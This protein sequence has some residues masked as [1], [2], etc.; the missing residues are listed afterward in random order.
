MTNA[1]VARLPLRAVP[2]HEARCDRSHWASAGAAPTLV[3]TVITDPRG[4]ITWC[5]KGTEAFLGKPLA[6]LIGSEIPLSIFD[7]AELQR[8]ADAAHVPVDVALL[9]VPPSRM[10]RRRGRG[11]D[12]GQ[13]DR[14]RGGGSPS[15]G[16]SGDE[17]P[18][19]IK[20]A[21]TA[22][23]GSRRILAIS[24]QPQH[25]PD[26]ELFGYVAHAV[27][28]TEEQ[29]TRDLLATALLREQEAARRLAALEEVRNNF[30]ATA[31]HELRTPL[32]SI[33]GYLELLEEGAGDEDTCRAFTSRIRRSTE[34][35][36][37]LADGLLTL[38]TSAVPH[39]SRL[40]ATD[41][42]ALLR[43]A[44]DPWSSPDTDATVP[45]LAVPEVPV[46]VMADAS[47]LMLALGSVIENA[48]TYTP[49]GGRISCA[50][51]VVDD[52]AVVTVADTGPG[53]LPWELPHVFS[54]FFR[55]AAARDG[56]VPGSGLG[57]SL[58]AEVAN[59]HGGRLTAADN[60]PEGA[61]FTLR[62]PRIVS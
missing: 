52:E 4:R 8:R 2:T 59:E 46:L 40:V 36:Q 17:G 61:V 16:R 34:R 35:L 15:G 18:Q 54:P 14:R 30:I 62:L 60:D 25:Q 5:C 26:G 10:D 20:W 43:D 38:S 45:E 48:V 11:P 47:R 23:D 13:L 56:A 22:A 42:G 3:L 28:V 7:P 57:L 19:Q 58:A 44:M 32:T 12:L 9:A 27:D 50:V 51:E 1:H 33:L 53:I 29:E 55:G 37:E 49:T 41:L 21:V 6:E 39:E 31:S 24:V